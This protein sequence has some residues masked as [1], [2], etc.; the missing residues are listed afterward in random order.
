MGWGVTV[1]VAA[2][3]ITTDAYPA[4]DATTRNVRVCPMSAVWVSYGAMVAPG[5]GTPDRYH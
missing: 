1:A 2:V 5:M 4:L 3:S